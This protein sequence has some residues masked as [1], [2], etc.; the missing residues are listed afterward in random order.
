MFMEFESRIIT[1]GDLRKGFHFD[2][3]KYGIAS[4][5]YDTR[6]KTFLSILIQKKMMIRICI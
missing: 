2:N 5:E 3:D 1:Y 4:Y 6:R